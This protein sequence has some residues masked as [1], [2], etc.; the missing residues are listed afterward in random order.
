SVRSLTSLVVPLASPSRRATPATA[1]GL[2]AGDDG[3]AAVGPVGCDRLAHDVK[4]SMAPMVAP[5]TH[6]AFTL[7][8]SVRPVR[9]R[10]GYEPHSDG[11]VGVAGGLPG[12]HRSSRSSSWWSLSPRSP[13]SLSL[14]LFF[15][16]LNAPPPAAAPMPMAPAENALM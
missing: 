8:T 15:V 13:L 3:T 4:A 9:W 1:A 10:R 5:Q 16:L 12:G 14:S 11:R 2:A 6:I 7:R